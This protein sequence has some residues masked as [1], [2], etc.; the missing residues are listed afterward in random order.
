LANFRTKSAKVEKKK[1]TKNV[2]KFGIL[3]KNENRHINYYINIEYPL[4]RA[5][6]VGRWPNVQ[7]TDVGQTSNWKARHRRFHY[8]TDV[9]RGTITMFRVGLLIPYQTRC[10]PDSMF[11]YCSRTS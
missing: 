5:M 2:E 7:K 9:N 6:P 8:M 3:K 11:I 4:D 10:E 1:E